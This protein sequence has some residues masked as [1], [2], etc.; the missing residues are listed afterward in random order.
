MERH[1]GYEFEIRNHDVPGYGDNVGKWVKGYFYVIYDPDYKPCEKTIISE[2]L[3]YFD[4]EQEARF[5]AIGHIEMLL[6]GEG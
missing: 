3:E 2:S 4:T 5:A 6:S 1:E